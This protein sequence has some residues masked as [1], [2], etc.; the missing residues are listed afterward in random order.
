MFN[1]AQIA[2]T[3]LS[4]S[5]S[6]RMTRRR[7]GSLTCLSRI[8][9]RWA[10]LS[11]GSGPFFALAGVVAPLVATTIVGYSRFRTPGEEERRRPAWQGDLE[12]ASCCGGKKADRDGLN[13]A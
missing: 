12:E 1:S 7:V 13:R 8:A 10:C 4:P 2:P 9:A 3:C 6:L 5:D 11:R